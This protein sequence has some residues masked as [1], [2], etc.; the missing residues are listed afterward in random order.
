ML[1]EEHKKMLASY[2]RTFL[3]TVSYALSQGNNDVKDILLVALISVIGPGIR[4][5]NPKDPAFG[6]IAD[7]AVAELS[8]LR[9]PAKKK[10][11]E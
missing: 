3:A 10:S 4:A 9:K 11:A 6:I 7:K 1:K 5:V 2:G 8:K